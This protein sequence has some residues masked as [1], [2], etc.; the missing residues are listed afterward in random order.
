MV[1]TQSQ[2]GGT[3]GHQRGSSTGAAGP[4]H[5]PQPAHLPGPRC[6]AHSGEGNMPFP[7]LWTEL[8]ILSSLPSALVWICVKI[9]NQSLLFLAG[10]G[11]VP[12]CSGH[13]GRG[14]DGEQCHWEPEDTLRGSNPQWGRIVSAVPQCSQQGA[15]FPSNGKSWHARV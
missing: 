11:R 15:E 8:L 12:H 14:G 6:R 7:V 3:P 1:L 13:H 10:G 2:E 4:G 9:K 5:E